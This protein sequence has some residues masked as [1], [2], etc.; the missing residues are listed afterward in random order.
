M[1]AVKRAIKNGLLP[2]E[3]KW[4]AVNWE[5][6]KVTEN[7]GKN[8][9]WDWE[10]RMRT[11]CIARK[12]DLTLEDT[13]KKTILLIDM[14]CLNESNK[15]AK[16]EKKDEK[17][18]T[19]MLRTARTTRRIYSYSDPNGYRM[20]RRRNKGTESEYKTNFRLR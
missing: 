20:S 4:Y 6:G 12:P 1:L 11:N 8:L 18:P 5:C 7:D 3:T 17:V 16:R 13:A 10:H 19:V 9:Y 15:E 2:E 14:A